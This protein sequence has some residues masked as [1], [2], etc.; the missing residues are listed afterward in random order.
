MVQSAATTVSA[1]LDERSAK[2]RSIFEQLRA[3]CRN[4]LDGWEERMEWGMPGYGP[5]GSA[6]V[7]S[8]NEQKRHIAFYVGGPS[9][10]RFGARLAGIDCGKGCIRYRNAGEL[11]LALLAE[12]L[13]DIRARGGP[14]C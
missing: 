5:A 7:V 4:E 13:R 6:N 11:D 2:T 12:M 10:E 8:F 9:I 3:L 1:W 14:M